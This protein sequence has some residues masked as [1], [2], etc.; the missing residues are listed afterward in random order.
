VTV[1]GSVLGEDNL[2]VL[3]EEHP[4]WCQSCYQPGY[5]ICQYKVR[6]FSPEK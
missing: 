4:P 2:V 5:P 1:F 3:G 6:H